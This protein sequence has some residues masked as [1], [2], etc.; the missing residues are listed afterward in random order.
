MQGYKPQMRWMGQANAV[1]V[2]PDHLSLSSTHSNSSLTRGP[3]RKEM[4]DVQHRVIPYAHIFIWAQLWRKMATGYARSH[5]DSKNTNQPSPRK[6][7]CLLK[8][9]MGYVPQR[10]PGQKGTAQQP[11]SAP[12]L[13]CLEAGRVHPGEELQ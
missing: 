2:L 3:D 5:H 1:W 12:F 6:R 11:A 7:P 4:V 13:F 8:A 9:W 10:H